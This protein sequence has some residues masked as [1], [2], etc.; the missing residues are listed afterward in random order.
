MGLNTSYS[1]WDGP[2]S[3]FTRWRNTLSELAGYSLVEEKSE[4]GSF[5][6]PSGI[7]WNKITKDNLN[8]DWETIPSDPFV[9]IMC[10]YDC[11]GHICKEHV[12][13][14]ADRLIELLPL[15]EELKSNP[16]VDYEYIKGKTEIFIKGLLEAHA[17]NDRVEFH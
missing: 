13:P 4:Y 11:E 14:L 9:I 8:G 7:D 10:H 5:K 17:N 6:T 15:I 2:Y 3:A 16:R 1:C 12:K